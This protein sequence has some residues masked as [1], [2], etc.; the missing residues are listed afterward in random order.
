MQCQS[1]PQK[2]RARFGSLGALPQ[3][4][5]LPQPDERERQIAYLR[6]RLSRMRVDLPAPEGPMVAVNWSA[7]RSRFT[8]CRARVPLGR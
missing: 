8:P 4:G 3:G 6:E 5:G 2:L 7:S 1:G